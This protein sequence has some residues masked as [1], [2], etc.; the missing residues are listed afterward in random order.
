MIIVPSRGWTAFFAGVLDTAAF[1]VLG[2]LRRGVW[3]ERVV[4]TVSTAGVVTVELGAVLTGSSVADVTGWQSGVPVIQRSDV[5]GDGQPVVS[6]FFIS[7]RVREFSVPV[8]VR[9]AEGPLYLCCRVRGDSASF[10]V[11][12][13]VAVY[14]VEAGAEGMGDGT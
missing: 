6:F 11:S 5:V 2:P 13:S 12:V 9:A 3:I 8:G 10:A 1:K 4:W 14:C 7:A